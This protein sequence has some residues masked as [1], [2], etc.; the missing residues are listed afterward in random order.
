[1]R[2]INAD[3]SLQLLGTIPKNGWQEDLICQK[4]G[5]SPS[6][7]ASNSKDPPLDRW[8]VKG[9]V[10]SPSPTLHSSASC[11]PTT[12]NDTHWYGSIRGCRI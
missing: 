7:L 12:N 11:D 8:L 1:M 4:A 10:D 2:I 5:E 6:S 3:P 9:N